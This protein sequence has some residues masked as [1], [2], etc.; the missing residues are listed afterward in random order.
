[1]KYNAIKQ[2]SI[3]IHRQNSYVPCSQRCK[4]CHEAQSHELV[5]KGKNLP[6]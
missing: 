3:L 4:L 6:L 1:M 2:S 5:N